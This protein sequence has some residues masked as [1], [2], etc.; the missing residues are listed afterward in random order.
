MVRVSNLIYWHITGYAGW[1]DYDGPS[2][3]NIDDIIVTSDFFNK[4][5]IITVYQQKY[6]FNRCTAFG[7]Q[8]LTKDEYKRKYEKGFLSQDKECT[9]EELIELIGLDAVIHDYPYYFNEQG[10]DTYPHS[11]KRYYENG[12]LIINERNEL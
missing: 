4:D 7:V 3:D 6:K 11:N 5:D 12:R 1:D 2:D 9:W 8:K 10:E